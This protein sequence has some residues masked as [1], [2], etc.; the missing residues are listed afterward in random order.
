MNKLFLLSI[1]LLVNNAKAAFELLILHNNDMH[2]RIETS[3]EDS[4]KSV[5][6]I[7]RLSTAIKN[8]RRA[9]ATKTGP[10]VLYLNAGDYYNS[11]I[12][13]HPFAKKIFVEFFN[14]LMPD[15]ACFGCHDLD[16][17][18]EH[19]RPFV[20]RAKYP[21]LAA[22][23]HFTNKT[24]LS[25]IVQPSIV[26]KVQNVEIGVVGY[27]TANNHLLY[28]QNSVVMEDEVTA[29][30]R[31]AAKLKSQGVPIIIALGHSG[32]DM[33]KRIAMEVPNVNVVI[34]GLTNTFLWNGKAPD[35]EEP[36]GPYPIVFN[37]NRKKVLLATTYGFTKYLGSLSITF[38]DEYNLISYT[39]KPL[40]LDDSIKED[41][42][43]LNALNSYH[44]VRSIHGEN[45]VLGHSIVYLSTS[46]IRDGETNF[47]NFITDVFVEMRAIK[48]TQSQ[49][50]TDTPIAL[51]N[52]G[53]VRKDVP[54]S[55]KNPNITRKMLVQAMPFRQR[56]VLAKILGST[57]VDTLEQSVRSNGETRG[58]EFLQVSGLRVVYDFGQKSGERVVRVKA[59]CDLCGYPNFEHVDPNRIYSVYVNTFLANGGDGHTSIKRDAMTIKPIASYG[60]DIIEDMLRMQDRVRPEQDERITYANKLRRRVAATISN[61]AIT[62]L[63][64]FL[65]RDFILLV[66]LT[67]RNIIFNF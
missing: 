57:L 50:W 56:L 47:G 6:G 65:L 63:K 39:G 28:Q 18:L 26:L 11:P 9:A 29:V 40:L 51:I 20:S 33:D 41:P 55:R 30:R 34:G 21:L 43:V 42:V 53:S 12:W 24:Y 35:S 48:R 31:E 27:I 10:P 67:H 13:T 15:A 14:M 59:Y 61:G 2:G 4:G 58:G 46:Q 16:Y 66:L 17:G 23:L 5:G 7:A 3:V 49:G 64:G 52:A 45:D 32:I 37:K 60:I 44:V 8:A 19:I 1:L 36:Q 62:Q 22:N 54:T 38:D 25:G